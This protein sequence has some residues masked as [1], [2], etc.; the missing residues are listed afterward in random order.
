MLFFKKKKKK[1]LSW[2]HTQRVT[3][4]ECVRNIELLSLCR[5]S[6]VG[7]LASVHGKDAVIEA[8]NTLVCS[9]QT[10]AFTKTR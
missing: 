9:V 6:A 2:I 8:E 7:F 5:Y 1:T 3:F 10:L 4:Q